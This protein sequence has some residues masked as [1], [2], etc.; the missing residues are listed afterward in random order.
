[1]DENIQIKNDLITVF[2]HELLTPLVITKGYL[3]MVLDRK[4]NQI[5]NETKTFLEK[6]YYGNERLITIVTTMIRTVDIDNN[7]LKYTIR[8]YSMEEILS[9]L[10]KKYSQSCKQKNIILNIIKPTNNN[11][12]VVVDIEKTREIIVYLIDN[13]L[14]FTDKGEITI[15]YQSSDRDGKQY[16]RVDIKDTGIGISQEKMP[17][18]FEKLAYGVFDIKEHRI[19]VGLGLYIAKKLTETQNGFIT[20]ESQTNKG[21]TFSLFLPLAQ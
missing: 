17:L 13:A 7:N 18:L 6:A 5:D 1:M 15:G 14:K 19:G 4:A 8:P 21:S 11:L 9:P 20:V 3:A 10:I 16:V 12:K 2:S